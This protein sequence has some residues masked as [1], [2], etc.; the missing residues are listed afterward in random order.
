M[1]DKDYE[2]YKQQNFP[3]TVKESRLPGQTVQWYGKDQ[4]EKDTTPEPIT[5]HLTPR[6]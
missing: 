1:L 2:L 5:L 4:Q 3:A 6:S